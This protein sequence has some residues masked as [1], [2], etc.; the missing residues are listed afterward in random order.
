MTYQITENV[1]KDIVLECVSKTLRND[2][3]KNFDEIF[4]GSMKKH[5]KHVFEMALKRKDYKSKVDGIAPQIIENIALV[6][7]CA[8]TH[9]TNN[10]RHWKMELR[11]H[12]LTIS[13]FNLKGANKW[14]DKESTIREVWDENDFFL[15]RTIELTINN[16][17][18]KENISTEDNAFVET[19]ADTINTFNTLIH[20]ICTGEIEDIDRFIETITK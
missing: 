1:L 20:I 11:G 14:E 19:V 17:F 6:R 18:K 4:E 9:T 3:G 16:K 5:K 13:R 10:L 7:H 15:P 12:L 2:N 8:I